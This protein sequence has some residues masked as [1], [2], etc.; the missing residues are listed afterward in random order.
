M[1]RFLA[2]FMV[3][4]ASLALW[5][6]G[7][8]PLL[9]RVEGNRVQFHYSYSLS[10]NGGPMKQV[11]DGEMLLEG[12]SYCL[13]GLGMEVRSDGIS[14]WTADTE[15]QE[16]IIEAVDKDDILTNPAVFISTYKRY[17]KNLKVNASGPDYLDVTV[18]LD[19]DTRARFILKDVRFLDPL[20]PSGAS[21]FTWDVSSLPSSWVVTDL[22]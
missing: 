22:R 8:I 15:A 19:E 21:D 3:S 7:S 5:A 13:S 14:R 17:G 1:K 11:T 10:R 4:L 12:N 2:L 9:D 16:M 20:G 6:Q 18:T